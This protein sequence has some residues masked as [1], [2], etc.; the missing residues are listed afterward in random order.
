MEGILDKINF[1]VDTSDVSF[2]RDDEQTPHTNIPIIK[3]HHSPDGIEWGY[4]GYGPADFAFNILLLFTSNLKEAFV[5][6]QDF[7]WKF[8]A[9]APKVGGTI[10]NEHIKNWIYEFRK[11]YNI[12]R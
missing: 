8:I 6:H 12:S 9:G 2:W 5:M 10:K 3:L 7:K 1:D 11:R 4:G